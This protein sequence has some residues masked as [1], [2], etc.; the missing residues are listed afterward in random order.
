MDKDDLSEH[1]NERFRTLP[2]NGPYEPK[3]NGESKEQDDKYWLK[4]TA[5]WTRH[6]A[7]ATRWGILVTF[8]F[9]LMI[10][11]VYCRQTDILEQQAKLQVYLA[12][13]R[14]TVAP[15]NAFL[16]TINVPTKPDV[17]FSFDGVECY[18]GRT[19]STQGGFRGVEIN[20][21]ANHYTSIG[22][23]FIPSK[24]ENEDL[25]SIKL[26]EE[27]FVLPLSSKQL[28]HLE[29]LRIIVII[30]YS[31]QSLEPIKDQCQAF[32]RSFVTNPLGTNAAW[33]PLDSCT[34]IDFSSLP[35][36]D[37]LT[38]EILTSILSK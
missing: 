28:F 14:I 22:Q 1:S 16:F 11:L 20:N 24:Y 5:E 8:T 3:E 21:C 31:Y 18:V 30:K 13:P 32:I 17:N 35:A 38:Q 7:I 27:T 36:T 25:H 26:R 4:Y 12:T 29:E 6:A 23:V 19:L 33:L 34:K 2:E 15:Q 10:L 37:N 9:S